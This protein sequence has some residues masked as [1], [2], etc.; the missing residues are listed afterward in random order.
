MI[1]SN[2]FKKRELRK[3]SAGWILLAGLGVSYVISGDFAGWNFGLDEGGFLG[4]L[5]AAF[6]MAIMYA[7]ICFSLA[8]LSAMI[9]TAGGGY[10]FAR[11]A[12]GPWGGYLTGISILIEYTAATAAI[13]TFIGSY[14]HNLFGIEGWIVYFVVYT[15]FIGIHTYGAGEALKLIL[16]IS[17]IAAFGLLVF[18]ISMIPH[19]DLNNLFDITPTDYLG[20]NRLLPFG[21]FGIWKALPFAMWFFL[22][23]EG[24]PLA[25]EESRNP[26]RDLPIGLIVGISILAIF[27]SLVLFCGIG[28]SSALQ[29]SIS[30]TPLVDALTIAY[31]RSTWMSLFVNVIG[32]VGLIASFFSFIYGYSR[33]LF[34]LSRAG[35][36]PRFLSLTNRKQ[37][38]VYAL[39]IPGV[40]GFCLSLTEQGELLILVAIF[41]AIISYI[42]MMAAHI[43]LQVKRPNLFRPYK[44]P[45]GIVT[46][47]TALVLACTAMV[48]NFLNNEW[49]FLITAAIYLILVGYFLFYSRH[50]L[51]AEAPGEVKLAQISPPQSHRDHGEDTRK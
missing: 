24:V 44:T 9:P 25:A 40:L 51:V 26:Q 42:L 43:F 4:L 46:S 31:G 7:C 45:G 23:I 36:L 8:E 41:G 5:I 34:A 37:A 30:S 35:Y 47:S 28:G 32:L 3:G 15:L 6:L 20:A 39:I 13:A 11:S 16:L 27:A 22:G 17:C 1:E 18:F 48:A 2:Y 38:P 12:F 14:S 29:L 10:G 33:L 21:Y 19:F 49:V 50:H